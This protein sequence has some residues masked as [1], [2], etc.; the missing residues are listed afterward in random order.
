MR[1][2]KKEQI[3]RKTYASHENSTLN[4]RLNCCRGDR[5]RFSKGWVFQRP[6][7]LLQDLIAHR[8]IFLKILL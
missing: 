8:K 6:I 2:K 7:F 5:G 3:L 4:L 1:K